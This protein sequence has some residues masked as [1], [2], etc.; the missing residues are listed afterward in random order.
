MAINP[1]KQQIIVNHLNRGMISSMVGSF[2]VIKPGKITPDI[3]Y[4]VY[5]TETDFYFIK[6]GG[7]FHNRYA[8]EKQLPDLLEFLFLPLFKK[9]ERK[10]AALEAEYDLLINNNQTS[11]L[12]KSKHNFSISGQVIHEVII[13]SK[14]TLHT[15]FHDNGTISFMLTNGKKHKFIIPKTTS[16]ISVRHT[17]QE[18]QPILS[19][20]EL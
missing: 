14:P 7:Q 9:A 11:D 2:H 15:A 17:L 8:Y 16:R 1:R 13:D 4:K 10:Q 6:M 18:S 3:Y 19:I 12:L 5:V 20:K